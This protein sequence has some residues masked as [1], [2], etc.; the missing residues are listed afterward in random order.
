MTTDVLGQGE[1]KES[2]IHLSAYWFYF[3][4]SQCTVCRV[5]SLIRTG[6]DSRSHGQWQRQELRPFSSAESHNR[7]TPVHLTKAN[8]QQ[9]LLNRCSE[10]GVGSPQPKDQQ[11]P[12]TEMSRNGIKFENERDR[13]WWISNRMVSLPLL[14]PS[15]SSLLLK[16]VF[17][18][19]VS[20]WTNKQINKKRIV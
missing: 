11:Q 1:K 12:C 9:A 6:V 17:F 7:T 16:H 3:Y 2:H 4:K 18:Y 15:S 14:R 5:F 19:V 20:S 8:L 10:S 13:D